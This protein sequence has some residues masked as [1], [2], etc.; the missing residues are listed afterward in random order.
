MKAY[1]QQSTTELYEQL[2]TGEHGLSSAEATAR[3][4]EYGP[5]TIQV[6][7]ESLWHKLS[8]PFRSVFML[9]LAIAAGA[10]LATNEQLDAVII[11][12]IIVI[13][14]VIYYLQRFSADRVLRALEQTDRQLIKVFRD[15]VEH[16]L[17]VEQL[18]PGDVVELHE[19]EKVP[20]DARLV[21]AD[22]VRSDE[23]LLTGESAPVAKVIQPAR[24]KKQVYDQTNMLFR[25]A[26]IVSGTAVAVVVATGNATEFGQIAALSRR[27]DLTSPVRAKID[28]LI[29]QIVGVVALISLGVFGLGFYRGLD[30]AESIRL[31][32]TL[33]VA[34]IPEGLPIAISVILVL[35]MRRMAKQQAL[36]RSMSAI[37]N[38]GSITTIAT[39]KTGTLTQNKLSIQDV[40]LPSEPLELRQVAEA[41]YLSVNQGKGELF[42]PLDS[43][44]MAFATSYHVSSV[45]GHDLV[46]SLT[47]EQEQAMSGNVWQ[48]AKG[49]ETYVKGAPERIVAASSLSDKRRQAIEERLHALTAKG[50]RVI[51]LAR[52]HRGKEVPQTLTAVREEGLE[53]LALIAVADELRAEAKQS[54]LDAQAAGVNVRMVTGDHAETAFAIGKEL[55]LVEQRSQV[56]DCTAIDQLSESELKEKVNNAQVFARVLPEYKHRILSILKTSQIVAMTGDGVNDVPALTNSHIG[57]AM[58]SGSQIAKEAGDIVLLDD[59]F[60][61]ITAALRQGRVIFDNIRRMLYY[62]LSS[63]LGEVLTV[64]A[65]LVVGLPLPLLP[66][67]ILWINLATDTSMVIPLGLEPAEYDVM[68]RPPRPPKQPIFTKAMISRMALAGVTMAIVAIAFFQYHLQTESAD[69]ARTVV[70]NILIVIQLAHAFNA[71]SEWQSVFARLGVMN[72]KFYVGLILTVGLHVLSLRG[73]LGPILHLELITLEDIIISGGVALTA[74][75]AVSELHKFIG[76]RYFQRN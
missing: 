7:T 49:Y 11:F 73:P 46:S 29:S 50:Y 4:A 65:A 57:I 62:L 3:L 61:S 54:V 72:F 41:V 36:V 32:L 64:V 55:G 14:V 19:G 38:I 25:G 44:L 35:G 16:E 68:S 13:S 30:L 22:N 33:S 47:F 26:F 67:Q 17:P 2:K 34:V 27:T 23:A 31:V 6:E 52:I 18:V 15:G 63:N 1:Y 59:N 28:R 60:S 48:D 56:F 12:A 40:W 5:N 69:Y 42:D 58:G 39:D 53:F 20:A 45:T 75:L 74:I 70:F 9:I 10:S 21:T 37:E 76:R 8:E 51:A 43:A 24:A 66:V 71:R